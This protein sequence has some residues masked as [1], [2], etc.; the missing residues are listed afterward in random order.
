MS[1]PP[2]ARAA[3][4]DW[5]PAL[6]GRSRLRDGSAQARA[7]PTRRRPPVQPLQPETLP[8][9]KQ[10]SGTLAVTR[11]LTSARAAAPTRATPPPCASCPTAR[12]RVINVSVNTLAP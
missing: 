11:L 2:S 10:L 5:P 12:L 4:A 3:S 7:L 1:R 8:G 9:G 6:A